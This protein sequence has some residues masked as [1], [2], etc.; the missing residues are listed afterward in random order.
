M[1]AAPIPENESSRL[2]TLRHYSILDSLSQ[3]EFDDASAL[4]A[5][6]CGTPVSLVS[7]IDQDR[8]W[9]KAATGT[10]LTETPRSQSFCAHTLTTAKTL[11]V[12]DAQRDPRFADNP[13]VTGASHIRFYAGAPL[14]TPDG[15]ALGTLCVLDSQPRRISAEQKA[16]LQTLARSLISV[17]ELGLRTRE[18]QGSN[19]VLERISLTD[20]LTAVGNRLAFKQR[21]EE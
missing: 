18:L 14:V 12:P 9:F 6:I 8:Q 15:H 1:P 5:L 16:A 20:P 2:A 13:L 4:A 11:I 17:M 10:E 7:L 21:M 3:P 19:R